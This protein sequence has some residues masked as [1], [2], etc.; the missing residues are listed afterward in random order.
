MAST[1]RELFASLPQHFDPEYSDGPAVV[2]QF[3]LSG[4]QGGQ[5]HLI[6]EDQTCTVHQGSHA[7]PH[8]TFTLSGEDC[9][10]LLNGKLD[11][12]SV[13]MSGRVQISGDLGQAMQLKLLFPSLNPE[14]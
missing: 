1:I 11:G 8:V 6:V 13:F 3:D 9:L 10:R 4:P 2:Y 7:D 14:S 12:A 5:Y